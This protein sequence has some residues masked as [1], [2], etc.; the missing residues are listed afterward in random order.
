MLQPIA[1]MIEAQTPLGLED[2]DALDAMFE[3][4]TGAE[5]A[6]PVFDCAHCDEPSERD[7]GVCPECERRIC[8]CCEPHECAE[9]MD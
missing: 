7:N 3:S 9:G 8:P 2:D 4:E 6:E 5:I 1:E